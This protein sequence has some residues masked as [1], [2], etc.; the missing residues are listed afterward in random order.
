[1]KNLVTIAI[2][3]NLW[4]GAARGQPAPPPP[5]QPA[6]QPY[7][8]PPQPYPPYAYP[9]PYYMAPAGPDV[10]P[11]DRRAEV[12][13]L[14]AGAVL[15][16]FGGLVIVD[17]RDIEDPGIATVSVVGTAA[18]GAGL[19]YLTAD[20]LSVDRGQ[21]HA[22]WVGMMVGAANGGLLAKPA[23]YSDDHEQWGPFVLGTTALGGAA[24]FGVALKA[25]LTTGQSLF[26]TTLAASGI[27]S[28]MLGVAVAQSGELQADDS[29][30]V[31][32]AIGLDAG[33]VAGLALS[34][35]VTWSQRRARYVATAT[36]IGAGAG[37]S[38]GAILTG[39]SKDARTIGTGGLIG[40]WG[41]M[42]AGITLTS[43]WEPD[44]RYQEKTAPAAAPAPPY[45]VL[46]AVGDGQFG[47]VMAGGF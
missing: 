38:G 13:M 2:V 43:G 18:A 22:A 37:I 40:L 15:G 23:G 30:L 36:L 7:P 10:S 14:G 31:A 6:P 8:Y 44:P 46:P 28:T 25:D 16:L 19:G 29:A 20:T 3:M 47:L 42:L 17:Q 11:S 27:A 21:A 41:G 1:M 9:Q 34:P 5:P 26:T 4:A 24:A 45:T 35:M 33:A 39:D 12:E 32:L